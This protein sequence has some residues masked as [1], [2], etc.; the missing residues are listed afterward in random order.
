[1][2]KLLIFRGAPGCGKSTFIKENNLDKYTLSTDDIRLTLSP[3]ITNEDGTIGINQAFNHLVFNILYESLKTKMER[4]EFVVVDST[5]SKPSDTKQFIKL[6]KIYGYTI[7]CI[8]MTSLPKEECKR[9][10]KLRENFRI[11]PEE[12]IDKMYHRFENKLPEEINMITPEE[13]DITNY[14]STI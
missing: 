9:R 11:V 3:P 12:V 8:D 10:N 5:N 6:S 7:D 13:F 1:M 14:I 2:K 4:G